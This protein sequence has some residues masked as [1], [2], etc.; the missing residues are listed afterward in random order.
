MKRVDVVYGLITDKN[1][2]KILMVKNKGAGWTLPGG[3]VEAGET[4][5]QAIIREVREETGLITEVERVVALNEAFF[6]HKDSQVLFVTFKMNVLN[7][8][9]RIQYP[10][11]IEEL[12]WV[13]EQTANKWM[14]YHPRG[15][16]SL[17]NSA[18]SYTSQNN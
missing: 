12:R 6:K 16:S 8:E 9:C 14:P 11:E 4:M 18:A 3:G 2:E 10:E 13:D 17:L 5:E 7:G 15:I 1:E